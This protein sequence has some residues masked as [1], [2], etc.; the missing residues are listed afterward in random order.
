MKK[1]IVILSLFIFVLSCNKR[2]TVSENPP[3]NEP[4][5]LQGE[6]YG[7]T[8]SIQYYSYGKDYNK[9]IKEILD[10]FDLSVNTYRP[11]SYLSKFNHSDRSSNAD[12]MLREL[13][14]ISKI[15]NIKSNGYFDPSVEPLSILWGFSKSS[16]KNKPTQQQ[17]DS[18]MQFVGLNHIQSK[19]DTLYKDDARFQ[20]SFNSITGFVNDKVADFLN[21][22]KIESYLIEIGGEVYAKGIKPDKSQ[23]TV[24]IDEPYENTQREVKTIVHL[25][26]EALAT[27]GNYRKF[28][29][30]PATGEKIVHTINPITG[31][32]KPS[33]LLSVTII[34]PTTAEADAMAT[35]TM[36]MGYEKALEYIKARQDLKFYLIW[37]DEHN[38]MQ[39]QGFNGFIYEYLK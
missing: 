33:K 34:A 24:G 27:S 19:G 30:D 39:H 31:L 7:S 4:F 5:V 23:W 14:D 35:A 15:F 29:I 36:A 12:K 28:H 37:L 13:V 38:Q 32:A 21:Q 17:I 8:Y 3:R 25:N 1:V 9:E 11:D 26:N 22:Q 18:V 20:L 16:V 6:A 10:Q 2:E